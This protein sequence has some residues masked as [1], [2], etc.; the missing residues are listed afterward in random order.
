MIRECQEDLGIK[1]MRDEGSKVADIFRLQPLDVPKF[2]VTLQ[3]GTTSDYDYVVLAAG[4]RTPLIAR[5]LGVG[6]SCP[7]YPLRGF[8][9]TLY[10]DAKSDEEMKALKAGGKSSNLLNQFSIFTFDKLGSPSRKW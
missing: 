2:R 4:I 3:D 6:A 7:T 9:L 1:Y 5:K 10:T 8:S